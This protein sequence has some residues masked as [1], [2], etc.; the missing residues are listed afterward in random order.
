MNRPSIARAAFAGVL[1]A[2]LFAGAFEAAAQEKAPDASGVPLVVLYVPLDE[3]ATAS[4]AGAELALHNA[5]ASAGRF[6]NVD[7]S[8]ALDP[9]EAQ[10]RRKAADDAAQH[11]AAGQKAYGELDTAASETHFEQAMRA[12]E[13]SDLRVNL[14][15]LVDAWRMKIASMVG[16][17]SRKAAEAEIRALLAVDPSAT[18]SPTYFPPELIAYAERARKASVSGVGGTLDVRSAP[19]GARVYVDGKLR[20]MTP[21]KVTGLPQS[22]HYL[23][24]AAPGFRLHQQPVGIGKIE[25]QLVD[26]E[27]AGVYRAARADLAKAADDSR[28]ADIARGLGEKLGVAQVFVATAR[29]VTGT[30]SLALDFLRVDVKEGEVLGASS[31]RASREALEEEVEDAAS[32]A[33][34]REGS[35]SDSSRSA[36]SGPGFRW[37]SKW[38][39]YALMGASVALLAGATYFGVSAIG[40]QNRFRQLPQ[41]DTEASRR[42][43]SSGRTMG[44]T[45]DLLGLAG[46]VAGGAGV[47]FTFLKPSPPETMAPSLAGAGSRDDLREQ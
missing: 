4:T 46:I 44:I 21:L 31:A 36:S 40:Q 34:R 26:A 45:A 14:S 30:P 23:A 10:K 18:F 47:Y 39:G 5:V 9:A 19:A 13:Q 17:G 29:E 43:A 11:F 15:A 41:T 37:K 35:G 27:L 24:V 12:Y 22:S 8:D 20:G 2:T 33:L 1:C 32:T 38:T 7:L 16:N 28:R 25:V 6:R 3:G 42:L